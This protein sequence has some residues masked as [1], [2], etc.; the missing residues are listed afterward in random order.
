MG[1]AIEFNKLAAW[2]MR[3]SWIEHVVDSDWPDSDVDY[4][5]SSWDSWEK[6]IR[7]GRDAEEI[8]LQQRQKKLEAEGYHINNYYEHTAWITEEYLSMCLLT[9]SMYA[10]F[11]VS[12]WA[13]V[14]TYLKEL[15]WMCFYAIQKKEASLKTVQQ[16]CNEALSIRVDRV[17]LKEGFEEL[18]ELRK[19][20]LYRFGDIEGFFK[21][22]L[23]IRF[24]EFANYKSVDAIR[25]LNN[26][27]KHDEGKYMPKSD[28]LDRH[29][30]QTLLMTWNIVNDRGEIS[31]S[32]LPIK[33]LVL[34]CSAFRKEL[35]E[36]IKK[37]LPRRIREVA[38]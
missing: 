12:L 23:N 28:E 34:A 26:C 15:A 25:L 16:S 37:E 29:I 7:N 31:Y 3:L 19:K 20:S 14:E 10:A 1:E 5:G 8:T 4:I 2:E 21:K 18:D 6:R 33:D 24:Q 13:R 38:K 35:V 32:K 22:N 9:N 11:I 17:K 36:K 27:F 30:D